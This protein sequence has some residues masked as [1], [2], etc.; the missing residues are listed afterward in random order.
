MFQLEFY[1][2]ASCILAITNSKTNAGVFYVVPE[3]TTCSTDSPCHTLGHYAE[4]PSC[5]ITN[6][7]VLFISGTHVLGDGKNL[8]VEKLSNITFKPYTSNK[9]VCCWEKDPSLSMPVI[10][11]N[12]SRAGFVFRHV[13]GLKIEGLKFT[14]CGL[15]F[16][17]TDDNEVWGGTVILLSITNFWMENVIITRSS[18]YGIF[19]ESI[20]GISSILNSLLDD[21]KGKR[22]GNI[23]FHGGNM[24]L[25]YYNDSCTMPSY[26][27][28]NST[29]FTA[30]QAFKNFASGLNLVLACAIQGMN[31]VLNNVTMAQN[32]GAQE[33]G[34]GGGNFASQIYASSRVENSISFFNSQVVNGSA[35]LGSGLFFYISRYQS[36]TPESGY[37]RNVVTIE[38]TTFVA[39]FAHTVGAGLYMRLHYSTGSHLCSIPIVLKNC[40]FFRNQ[41]EAMTQ[42]RGGVAVNIV[43]FQVQ[44]YK[45][46]ITPQYTTIFE[47]CTFQEHS[48][49][50]H[51]HTQSLSSGTVYIEEHSDVVF[52]NCTFRDNRCTG[53]AAV[54]SYM[55]FNGANVIENNTAQ[56]GGGLMLNDNSMIQLYPNAKL[57]ISQNH[58]TDTGGGIYAQSESAHTILPCFFQLDTYILLNTTAQEEIEIQLHNNTANRTGTDLYGGEID[59]CFFLTNNEPGT[60][61]SLENIKSG[62]VFDNIFHYSNQTLGRAV[63]SSNPVQVCLCNTSKNCTLQQLNQTV[64]PGEAFNISAVVVGQRQ[65]VVPD[66]IVVGVVKVLSSAEN[67]FI[68]HLETTQ[69][70]KNECTTLTYTMYSSKQHQDV[71]LELTVSD[72]SSYTTPVVNLHITA[73][74][75][76]FTLVGNECGC[77][78]RLK[79]NGVQCSAHNHT[80]HRPAQSWIGYYVH[81]SSNI[82]DQNTEQIIFKRYCP[83]L[84]C[85]P[86][87]TEIKAFSDR[88]D[89]D[90]QCFMKRAGILCGGC[91]PGH[92]MV[93]GTPRCVSC[94]Q[95][96]I[97]KTLEV[98]CGVALAGI[99]L[100]LFLMVLNLTVTDGTINGIIFYANIIEANK[101]IYF[102]LRQESDPSWLSFLHIFIAWLNLDMGIQ[103]CFY[104]GMDMYMKTWLQ[105]LFP[106]YIWLIAGLIIW[107]SRKY[108][109]MAR[110]MQSNGTQILATLILLSYAKL[111]RAVISGLPGTRLVTDEH[112]VTVW[113]SDGN[114]PYLKGKHFVLFAASVLF[115][116]LVLPFTF[117]L[118]FIKYLPR[119]SPLR[120][121]RWVNKLKPF[122]DTYTGIYRDAF[123]CWTGVLLLV[124]VLLLIFTVFH[125]S[126]IVLMMPVIGVCSVLLT[127]TWLS[128]S[129]IYRK[130]SL[131]ILE[132][133]LV[134]NLIFWSMMTAYC[135]IQEN[136]QMKYI[137]VFFFA[138]LMFLTFC[139]II[140]SSGYKQVSRTH[141]W[142]KLKGGCMERISVIARK[143]KREERCTAIT[144][145]V[146]EDLQ[147][148]TLEEVNLLANA[149]PTARYDALREPLIGS[150]SD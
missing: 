107:L 15:P 21:N 148:C 103:T 126:N 133:W 41:L 25:L 44:G 53:I 140:C 145:R 64:S 101:S 116:I 20:I 68:K 8:T 130:K 57:T 131:D 62:P 93:F 31:F 54:H 46:H 108:N 128:G 91:I 106:F 48:F 16:N 7:T 86:H 19:G 17:E 88:I 142:K 5:F 6:S 77:V 45:V 83:H 125:F 60:S 92:S 2:I 90:K 89:Q 71:S 117:V 67:A 120:I 147:E 39:N 113:Y 146:E 94:E 84:Y 1:V 59:S 12:G 40:S 118:L 85:S 28:I 3:E 139:G 97:W 55:K 32:K 4:N 121:F 69:K 96:N 13:F 33:E 51:P 80:I 87:N 112:T 47:N 129:G 10:S 34:Y 122:F 18:G 42:T 115:S 150:S 22:S 37:S 56:N 36:H 14:E 132:A 109:F 137:V 123:H 119:L 100:V 95:T 134:L 76:G 105:F 81:N 30:G 149:P 82:T 27:Y 111:L 38:N 98:L 102:P 70:T 72:P 65:G 114:V 58:A 43:I 63:I 99:A 104:N 29:T 23:T 74:P 135:E 35:Y 110:I 78:P 144:E 49:Q 124:R 9:R 50:I 66:S 61:K 52:E 24:Q 75:I 73:C 11:C 26:F 138:D 79:I 141:L 143:L 136:E 127:T